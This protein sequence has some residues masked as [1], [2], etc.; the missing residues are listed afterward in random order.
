MLIIQ[1]KLELETLIDM[2]QKFSSSSPTP[3]RALRT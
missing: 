3:T 1:I 2:N